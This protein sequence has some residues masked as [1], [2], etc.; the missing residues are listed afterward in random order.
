M[1]DVTMTANQVGSW[2]LHLGVEL[3][4]PLAK[5]IDVFEESRYVDSLPPVVDPAKLTTG[6]V[7]AEVQRVA[8]ELA[9]A[10]KH[11]E[12]KRQ[13]QKALARRIVTEAGEAVPGVIDQI[14]PRFE[15][16][17]Q[18]FKGAVRLLPRDLTPES[19]VSAGDPAVLAALADA[20]EAA[21]VIHGV[22][23]WLSGLVE[24]PAYAGDRPESGLSVT[25]PQT[26][27]ELRQINTPGGTSLTNELG[28]VYVNAARAGVGFEMHTPVESRRILADLELEATQA[29]QVKIPGVMGLA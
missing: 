4:K 26:L 27:S 21:G 20:R 22:S 6:N 18:R 15:A 11:A 10:E 5:L 13:V 8:E 1:F 29:A 12:A 7:A 19:I 24:L 23:V 25:T 17:A 9:Q 2:P 16:E 3:P 14:K 28:T